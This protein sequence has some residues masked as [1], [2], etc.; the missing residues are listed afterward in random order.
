MADNYKELQNR[1]H[2][3]AGTY[4]SGKIFSEYCFGLKEIVSSKIKGQ[5]TTANR[6]FEI[7]AKVIKVINLM[8]DDLKRIGCDLGIA[9]DEIERLETIIYEIIKLD[10]GK[11]KRVLGL[12]KKL[13]REEELIEA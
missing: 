2:L 6:L 1:F 12:V 13:Q 3:M 5:V 8:A 9:D 4:L 10:E 11:Q 7:E